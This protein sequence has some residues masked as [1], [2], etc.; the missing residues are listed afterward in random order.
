MKRVMP[1]SIFLCAF[2][3]H[4][5]NT[6]KTPY[7]LN[8][9]LETFFTKHNIQ[10]DIFNENGTATIK[11]GDNTVVFIDDKNVFFNDKS[12]TDS[13][14]IIGIVECIQLAKKA[15]ALNNYSAELLTALIKS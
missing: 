8:P 12:I 7:T 14:S 1:L 10:P 15:A 11:W 4:A 6:I 2:S 3:A 5:G 13:R 9:S